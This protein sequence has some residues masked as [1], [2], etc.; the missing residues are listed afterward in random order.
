MSMLEI[1]KRKES[2]G[3]RFPTFKSDSADYALNR[4][5]KLCNKR[6]LDVRFIQKSVHGLKQHVCIV[7]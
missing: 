2:L 1:I 5:L 3:N 6:K 4:K 7:K